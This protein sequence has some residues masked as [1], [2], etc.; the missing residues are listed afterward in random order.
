MKSENKILLHAMQYVNKL[1]IPLENHYYHSYDH[2]IEVMHRAMYLAE[3][4]GLSYEDKEMLGLAG[5]FHDTGFVIQ[6]DKNEPFWAKIA[7]NYLKTILYPEDRIEKIHSLILATDPD[8]K[9]GQDIYEQIIKDADM[10]NLWR[11][12]FLSRANDLKKEREIIQHIKKNDAQWT[13]GVVQILKEYKY[14]TNTQ[15]IERNSKKEE[16]LNKMLEELEAE[17]L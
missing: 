7:K 14:D 8:Y 1:L 9:E 15:K 2:A 5:L 16:N 11:D 13:H 17:E 10:D 12:D 6:Y 4:E 3:K